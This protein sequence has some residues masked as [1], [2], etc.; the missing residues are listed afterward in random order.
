MNNNSQGTNDPEII[1]CSLVLAAAEV[2]LVTA[3]VICCSSGWLLPQSVVNIRLLSKWHYVLIQY[4]GKFGSIPLKDHH[5]GSIPLL[6]HLHVGP[7]ESMTCGVHGIYLKFGSFN[8]IDPIVPYAYHCRGFGR[9]ESIEYQESK[10]YSKNSVSLFEMCPVLY[11]CRGFG[12]AES[13]EY[14]ESKIYSK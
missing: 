14:Q 13:T 3:T 8:G 12:R 7:H 5:F 9:A 10:I 11:N 2:Q 4:T 1:M 6:S